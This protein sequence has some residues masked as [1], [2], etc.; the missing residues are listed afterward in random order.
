MDYIKTFESFNFSIENLSKL[1][2]ETLDA[3]F[4]E[5]F[6]GILGGSKLTDKPSEEI[7]KN[8]QTKLS[9]IKD[10]YK[11]SLKEYIKDKYDPAWYESILNIVSAPG[12]GFISL[13]GAKTEGTAAMK[14][15]EEADS[16]FK[17]GS[18]PSL[19][20]ESPILAGFIKNIAL[21]ALP[22]GVKLVEGM[23]TKNVKPNI[24]NLT[25]MI[26]SV[27]EETANKLF[28][29]A[30]SGLN[31][32][33]SI[34]F[35]FETVGVK[36]KKNDESLKEYRS[37]LQTL[38]E[39]NDPDDWNKMI[40]TY[41]II[42]TLRSQQ[43]ALMAAQSEY[44]FLTGTFK[45]SFIGSI[46]GYAQALFEIGFFL[47]STY[48][49]VNFINALGK[50]PF[51]SMLK[52]TVS[53][54]L[55]T[56]IPGFQETVNQIMNETVKPIVSNPF[57]MGGVVAAFTILK[58]SQIQKELDFEQKEQF[59]LLALEQF[60][61]TISAVN[62]CLSTCDM[63][64]N[65]FM[66]FLESDNWTPEKIFG[67]FAKDATD[68]ERDEYAK[69]MKSNVDRELY[70]KTMSELKSETGVIATAVRS[71]EVSNEIRASLTPDNI[72]NSPIRGESGI[73]N[74]ASSLGIELDFLKK[75]EDIFDS[76]EEPMIENIE[77]VLVSEN[78]YTKFINKQNPT[79][80]ALG[81]LIFIT[82]SHA[83]LKYAS[84]FTTPRRVWPKVPFKVAIQSANFNAQVQKVEIRPFPVLVDFSEPEVE[85]CGVFVSILDNKETIYKSRV[86]MLY[87]ETGSP[88]LV[89]D[90]GTS[91]LDGFSQILQDYK[92]NF[93]VVGNADVSG[94]QEQ[95][96]SN[97]FIGNR[98]LSEER[99]NTFL[100]SVKKNGDEKYSA[101]GCGK[102]Y[103]RNYTKYVNKDYSSSK[104]AELEGT[105]KTDEKFRKNMA[106][107]RRIEIIIFPDNVDFREYAYND[108]IISK[109]CKK[110]YSED[111]DDKLIRMKNG[112]WFISK[113]AETKFSLFFPER[114]GKKTNESNRSYV[115]TFDSFFNS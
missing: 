111:D 105:K 5:S 113:E 18:K 64:S 67:E 89:K 81:G 85:S 25:D 74:F 115:L 49:S 86:G 9:G 23:E 13:V 66:E 63:A 20:E 88:I 32:L 42:N 62:V 1:N 12:Q 78:I 50:T 38:S 68:D 26:Y 8:L 33:S 79:H 44:E 45:Q 31:D 110:P 96:R 104:I 55:P 112:K 94:P 102:L 80:A 47:L 37:K 16:K 29:S 53:S 72:F 108:P 69:R 41:C 60:I 87:F 91:G 48:L 100:T 73:Y 34:S 57:F 52:D 107:D 39:S 51:I 61:P 95:K 30:L 11:S 109:V 43:C 54:A 83:V 17:S 97:G 93:I 36:I 24:N 56:V 106:N 15:R 84:F 77:S 99:A 101:V 90:K 14:A 22:S 75:I 3:A 7:K 6:K 10:N 4:K 98:Q 58:G 70:N 35:E 21:S 40:A 19:V 76:I 65:Q 103:A 59:L 82:Q 2:E 92:F 71:M 114:E 46:E 27:S 28:E